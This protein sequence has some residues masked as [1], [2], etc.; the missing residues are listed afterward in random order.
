M[1]T[2]HM[3]LISLTTIAFLFVV[4][5]GGQGGGRPG[6]G[7]AD[8]TQMQNG[9]TMPSDTMPTD[10]MPS[11]TGMQDTADTMMQGGEEQMGTMGSDARRDRVRKKLLR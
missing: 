1:K 11:D 5:C 2:M 9:D 10:T 7:A 8:T 4:G 3:I 6:G